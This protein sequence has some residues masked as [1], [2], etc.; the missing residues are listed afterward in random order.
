[1]P[2]PCRRTTNTIG[3]R[4]M[5]MNSIVGLRVSLKRSKPGLSALFY[6]KGGGEVGD[7]FRGNISAGGL[8]LGGQLSAAAREVAREVGGGA[9]TSISEPAPR[10]DA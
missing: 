2:W 7:N 1:M 8:K 10:V 9:V 3:P 5:S 4:S 6:R